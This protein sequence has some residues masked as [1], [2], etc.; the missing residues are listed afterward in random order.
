MAS[1]GCF[2]YT[3]SGP[4]GELWADRASERRNAS[5]SRWPAH[6]SPA[7]DVNVG[8]QVNDHV[9]KLGTRQVGTVFRLVGDDYVDVLFPIGVEMVHQDDLE[10]ISADPLE[11]LLSGQ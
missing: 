7:V 10:R 2:R 9:R 5:G 4:V 6:E 3:Y 11:Q 8:F 1:P